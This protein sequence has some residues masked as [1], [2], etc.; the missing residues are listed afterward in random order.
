[1]RAC[2]AFGSAETSR[3]GFGTCSP[4]QGFPKGLDKEIPMSQKLILIVA[5]AA[6]IA[7]TAVAQTV[8]NA[9]QNSP[10]G[11]GDQVKQAP[12]T[13][14]SG[15]VGGTPSANT[16]GVESKMQDPQRAAPDEASR[17]STTAPR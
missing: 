4:S 9:P 10:A 15:Q 13:G 16:K 12:R 17:S 7:G 14:D 3:N 5:A 11:V 6:L 8:N 1:M 2:A